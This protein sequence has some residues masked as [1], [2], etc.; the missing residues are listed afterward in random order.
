MVTVN[1]F[2]TLKVVVVAN[3]EFSEAVDFL[4]VFCGS[5]LEAEANGDGVAVAAVMMV[6]AGPVGELVDVERERG[7]WSWDRGNGFLSL[8]ALSL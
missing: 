8:V 5:W 4:T 6:A 3:S 1:G 2:P 7:K